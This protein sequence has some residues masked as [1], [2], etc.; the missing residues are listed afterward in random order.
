MNLNTSE[1]RGSEG[2]STE[3][4]SEG[5][6]KNF[7]TPKDF[8]ENRLSKEKLLR[9][10]DYWLKQGV[11]LHT[12]CIPVYLDGKA[13]RGVEMSAYK[14]YIHYELMHEYLVEEIKKMGYVVEPPDFQ[15]Q[16]CYIIKYQK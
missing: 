1:A 11:V 13:L 16:G 7:P 8:Q 6:N 15:G 10:F 9:I 3:G 12:N 4:Q 2:A 5:E 14:L